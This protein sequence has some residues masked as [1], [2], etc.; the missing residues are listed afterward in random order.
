MS[1]DVSSVI[2][3]A[4][5]RDNIWPVLQ[6]SQSISAENNSV[7]LPITGTQFGLPGINESIKYTM[8]TANIFDQASMTLYGYNQIT[9]QKSI[10]GNYTIPAILDPT[11][12]T[13]QQRAGIGINIDAIVSSTRQCDSCGQQI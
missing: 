2:P 13:S 6:L 10:Y 7:G 1:D 8:R 5:S 3:F 11:D 4:L 12:P 9:G